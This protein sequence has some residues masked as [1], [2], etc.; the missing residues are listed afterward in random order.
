[1]TFA[2]NSVYLYDAISLTTSAVTKYRLISGTA[3][4]VVSLGKYGAIVNG[5]TG[6]IVATTIFP[7]W[8]N[9]PYVWAKVTLGL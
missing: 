9:H 7:K 4:I 3:Y 8:N 6:E 5:Y 2:D 1:M